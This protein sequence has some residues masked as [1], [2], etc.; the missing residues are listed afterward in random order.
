MEFAERSIAMDP[1]EP[2]GYMAL[3]NLFILDG[4]TTQG[5]ELRRKAVELA[6]N[7]FRV[8][9]GLAMQFTR[10][11]QEQE[12]VE[13]FERAI[14]LSPKHQWW[15]PRGYGMALHLVGRKQEALEW[16]QKAK[17][18]K[19]KHVSVNVRLVAVYVDLDRMDDARAALDEVLRLNP[20]LTIS[21]FQQL[22]YLFQ[23]PKRNDWYKDLLMRAGLPE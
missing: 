7:D 20:R 11:G 14:R 12:A 19:S 1:I 13:L 4:N 23:D 18:L 8:A 22:G 9:A 5:V 6:P 15:V 10:I 17:S 3:G 21:K 2:L 16:F